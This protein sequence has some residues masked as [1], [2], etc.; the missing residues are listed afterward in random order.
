[1]ERYI[2]GIDAEYQTDPEDKDRNIILSYQWFCMAGDDQW[3]GIHY[4][5]QGQR[6]TLIDWIYRAIKSRPGTTRWPDELQ[7]VYH[8]GTAELSTVT[9]WGWWRKRLRLVQ[10]SFVTP[11]DPVRATI[12]D[13]SRNQHKID[14]RVYDTIL[15]ADGRS[16]LADLGEAIGV[17][18]VEVS[19]DYKSQMGQLLL[20]DPGLFERYAITD[21]EITA[22]YFDILWDR[23]GY[24]NPLPITVGAL[25][26][27]TLQEF[28]PDLDEA[29]GYGHVETRT[30]N[31][32]TR[33]YRTTRRR[34][35]ID[36]FASSQRDFARQAFHGGRNECYLFGFHNGAFTDFDLTGAYPTCLAAV[37]RPDWR[38]ARQ[39]TDP[40]DFT[41]EEI[42]FAHVRWEFPRGTRFPSLFTSDQRGK[43]RG[44]IFTRTGEGV[45]TGPEIAVARKAG[46]RVDI[47]AGVVVPWTTDGG[48][49]YFDFV[50]HCLENRAR[51]KARGDGVGNLF[52]K[53]M[54]N[55]TYGK[56]AQGLRDRTIFNNVTDER[57]QLPES[58]VTCP[59][60][61]SYVTGL[62]RAVIG[63]ILLNL[64]ENVVVANAIT[65]GICCTASMDE[66]LEASGDAAAYFGSI[67]RQLTGNPEEPFLEIK[68]RTDGILSIRTRMHTG[69]VGGL[70]AAAGVSLRQYDPVLRPAVLTEMFRTRRWM[71]RDLRR[72]LITPRQLYEHG[73]DLVT[74]EDEMFRSMEYDFKRRPTCP[75]TNSDHLS[76]HTEPWVSF[77]EFEQYRDAFD[78]DR[79]TLKT[80]DDLV[81]FLW[82][83]ENPDRPRNDRSR[84]HQ[85][86]KIDR[87]SA[88]NHLDGLSPEELV[89]A[90]TEFQERHPEYDVPRPKAQDFRNDR[91]R[92]IKSRVVRAT[93]SVSDWL[94]FHGSR[95]SEDKQ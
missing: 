18:K 33:Q 93:T 52:W 56:T 11:T 66:M 6:I 35:M 87:W 77:A 46:A 4:P 92:Q 84:L 71:S 64:P 14:V 34:A 51:A 57:D 49:P 13:Q 44:L 45:V 2:I 61:A 41:I 76:F 75:A 19:A 62:C 74:V 78:K 23:F 86:V 37:G 22:R 38:R 21:A 54:A 90:L 53:L 58:A 67:R 68:H 7:L 30:Y 63:E 15:L 10:S 59:Y 88:A 26:V 36:G 5:K 31:A 1:M 25:A 28:R 55:S 29:M 69:M 91:R 47:R 17:P 81:H 12:T 43:G 94:E 65:D 80:V 16:P 72:R 32:A 20:D 8:F 3:S 89:E 40:D 27:R 73:G 50:R 48:S 95:I 70:L 83:V 82:S 39:T 60:V 85:Q 24:D 79:R 9:D 42:G